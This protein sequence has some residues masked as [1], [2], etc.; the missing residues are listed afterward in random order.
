MTNKPFILSKIE[1][2]AGQTPEVIL[3]RKLF[4]FQTCGK[5]FWGVGNSLGRDIS[6]HFDE[7]NPCLINWVRMK[8]SPQRVDV[9]P[10][11]VMLWTR[12]VDQNGN[13]HSM[14]Q[15]VVVTSRAHSASRLKTSHYALVCSDF[16]LESGANYIDIGNVVNVSGKCLG[17]SQVTAIVRSSSGFVNKPYSIL[18]KGKLEVPYQ[19]KLVGGRLLDVIEIEM[20]DTAADISRNDWA[21]IADNLRSREV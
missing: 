2:E 18:A 16:S 7:N 12:Y 17:G 15:G 3:V 9:A 20:I 8:S 1:A 21:E 11:G 5:M 4:E 6:N 13:E 10:A 19:V 14:P